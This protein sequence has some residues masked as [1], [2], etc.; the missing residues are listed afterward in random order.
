[1][2]KEID[3][4]RVASEDDI[5]NIEDTVKGVIVLLDGLIFADEGGSHKYQKEGFET[6][7]RAL[8]STVKDLEKMKKDINYMQDIIRK[9]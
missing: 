8:G 5:I 3:F 1:M 7:S 4:N 9:D 2:K 6:L